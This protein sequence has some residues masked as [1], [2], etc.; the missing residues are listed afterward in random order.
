MGAVNQRHPVQ[1]KKFLC[2]DAR[3]LTSFAPEWKS[4]KGDRDANRKIAFMTECA[5]LTA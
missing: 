2:H 1:Q 3:N 5:K 4:G